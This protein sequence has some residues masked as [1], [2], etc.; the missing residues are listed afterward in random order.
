MIPLTYGSNQVG[1]HQWRV[2]IDTPLGVFYSNE[3]TLERVAAPVTVRAATAGTKTVGADTNTWGVATGAPEA[4]VW[5]EVQL[6]SGWSRSQSRTT[7]AD[8][9]FVIPLTYGR[10][11]PGTHRWR[12]AV[13]TADGVF[14]SGEFTLTRVTE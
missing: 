4:E 1:N 11:Q 10:N 13:Q 5:T 6:T 7:Q 14:H 9:S 2:G 3:F 8:G 12:V